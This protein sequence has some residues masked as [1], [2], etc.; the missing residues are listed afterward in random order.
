MIENVEEMVNVLGETRD[1]VMID[2]L[3]FMND[4]DEY[5]APTKKVASI[6]SVTGTVTEKAPLGPYGMIKET[7]Y[8]L[9]IELRGPQKGCGKC[10]GRG[11]IG[12]DAKTQHP[13]PCKCIYVPKT[14]AE[15]ATQKVADQKFA[16]AG[17]NRSAKRNFQRRL[18]KGNKHV[19]ADATRE[20]TH[21]LDIM[22]LE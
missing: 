15:H 8:M 17:M 3:S 11:Y 19:V 7:S 6:D 2:D 21:K 5:L 10:G 9:G 16:L 4:A 14:R 13:V 18:F 20:S 12:R 22:P 1:L